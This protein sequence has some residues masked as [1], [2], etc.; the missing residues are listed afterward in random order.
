MVRSVVEGGQSKAA[1]ARQFNRTA[2]D[3]RQVGRPF[4]QEVS[5]VCGI[6][7]HTP[8]S[9]PSQT[10]RATCAVVETLRRQRYTGKQI[11]SEVGGVGNERQPD[12]AA[13]WPQQ[14]IGP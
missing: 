6:V 10:P 7:L 1:A 14:A 13:A 12:P 4:A 11:A 9:S 8:H 2:E 5:M 3:R